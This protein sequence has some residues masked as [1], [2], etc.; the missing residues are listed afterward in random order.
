MFILCFPLQ[1][2]LSDGGM[3]WW[4]TSDHTRRAPIM[5][6]PLPHWLTLMPPLLYK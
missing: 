5:S 1:F 3:L 4:P 2:L 6:V